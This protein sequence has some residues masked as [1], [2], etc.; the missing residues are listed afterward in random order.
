MRSL[1]LL[2]LLATVS[3]AFVKATPKVPKCNCNQTQTCRESIISEVSPCFDECHYHLE[4]LGKSDSN[5]LECFTDKNIQGFTNAEMCLL[6]EV[7]DLCTN[8][9]ETEYMVQPDYTPY[10]N[11]H[12]RNQSAQKLYTNF[13]KKAHKTFQTFQSFYHCA[14]HCVHKKMLECLIN[15]EQCVVELPKL[16]TF[17]ESMNNCAKNHKLVHLNLW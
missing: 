4:V 2:P 17:M 1:F 13:E 6:A 3:L 7:G 14:K 10:T 9:T 15:V 8:S 11:F 5:F 12:Y 16:D